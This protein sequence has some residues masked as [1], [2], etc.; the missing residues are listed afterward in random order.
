[1]SIY[2]PVQQ[3]WSGPKPHNQLQHLE[4]VSKLLR[5]TEINVSKRVPIRKSLFYTEK[6][7]T[8][9]VNRII[10]NKRHTY[11][12]FILIACNKSFDLH[13]QHFESQE[14]GEK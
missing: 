12:I 1:M 7:P 11:T 3:G 2:L 5:I 8:Y 6:N 10:R 9:K 13:E 14:I 4:Q